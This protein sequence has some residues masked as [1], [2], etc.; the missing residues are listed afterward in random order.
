MKPPELK[1][2][3]AILMGYIA[4]TVTL[5]AVFYISLPDKMIPLTILPTVTPAPIAVYLTGAVVK[6]GVLYVSPESRVQDGINVAGG[7][8]ESADLEQINL[9]APIVDGQKIYVPVKGEIISQQNSAS[10]ATTSEKLII[11]LNT[12]SAK[13]LDLLPGIGEEKASTIIVEREKRGRFQ[14]I[15][16]LMTVSGIS[17]NLFLQIQP[18]LMLD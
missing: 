11:H 16:D 4:G 17:K 3:Q 8:L 6:P 9:A 13:D 12:A 15:E 5:A 14:S 7:P 10:V 18:F 1:I 2:W